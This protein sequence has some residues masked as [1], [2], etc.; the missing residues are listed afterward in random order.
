MNQLVLTGHDQNNQHTRRKRKI[1][2][3]SQSG[4]IKTLKRVKQ[5]KPAPTASQNH[6]PQPCSDKE[7]MTRELFRQRQIKH[8][9]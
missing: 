7:G 9:G 8:F 6:D 2:K 4:K 3:T 1:E 5:T